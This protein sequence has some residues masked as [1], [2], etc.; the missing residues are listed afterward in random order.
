MNLSIYA[1]LGIISFCQDEFVEW[2]AS[3]YVR[4]NIAKSMR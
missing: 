1:R 3:I 2:Q 4:I